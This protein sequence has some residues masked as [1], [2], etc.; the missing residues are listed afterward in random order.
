[1]PIKRK[2]F[3]RH[4]RDEGARFHH[5]GGKHDVWQG[6]GGKSTVPR[7]AEIADG[8]ARKIC[9]QLGIGRPR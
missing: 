4:L 9:D 2:V 6:P 7:H 8:T 5:H 1:V 3:E